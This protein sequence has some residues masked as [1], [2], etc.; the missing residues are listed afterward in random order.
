MVR[1]TLKYFALINT[2]FIL[3]HANLIKAAEDEYIAQNGAAYHPMYSSHPKDQSAI[4]LKP[5]AQQDDENRH[6]SISD[7][8]FLPRLSFPKSNQSESITDRFIRLFTEKVMQDNSINDVTYDSIFM[9]KYVD[10]FFLENDYF[11]QMEMEKTRSIRNKIALQAAWDALGSIF[12]QTDIGQKVAKIEQ[13]FSQY[14]VFE[15]SKNKDTG[16]ANMHLPGDIKTAKKKETQNEYRFSLAPIFF[17]GSES[18]M[19]HVSIEIGLDYY[20][21][22][23][24]SAYN[25][26]EKE[27]SFNIE[28]NNI[29][30]LLGL[31]ISAAI[32]HKAD[33]YTKGLVK[34]SVTF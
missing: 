27:Y 21:T 9:L 20:A 15:F 5:N 29:N 7:D 22:K 34:I 17:T 10:P 11:Y 30:A 6:S 8:F 13:K 32:L 14:L 31:N 25:I 33:S 18:L 1:T 26:D 12:N 16:I 24:I 23:S 19:G 3:L 28:N 4:D 2:V